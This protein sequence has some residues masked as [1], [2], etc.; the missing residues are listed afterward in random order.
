M[1]HLI[2]IPGVAFFWA[3]LFY[4]TV[5]Y[6][7]GDVL[8][9]LTN[10]AFIQTVFIADL[11][12]P[13]YVTLAT[14][15]WLVT[16][17]VTSAVSYNICDIINMIRTRYPETGIFIF[18]H[19]MVIFGAL[20]PIWSGRYFEIYVYGAE[21]E[22]TSIAYNIHSLFI[23]GYIG[24]RWSA[25]KK[26]DAYTAYIL[27]YSIVRTIAIGMMYGLYLSERALAPFWANAIYLIISTGISIFSLFSVL[28]M[29]GIPI[30]LFH[31]RSKAQPIKH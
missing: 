29:L 11:F 10:I 23:L 30:R 6:K 1:E 2:I 3:L 15:P 27:F 26:K 22:W 4:F 21:I 9:S 20:L 14:C 31:E 28:D 7:W 5:Q 25:E 13:Y 8:R 12:P 18:H 24:S 19:L 16:A 17:V